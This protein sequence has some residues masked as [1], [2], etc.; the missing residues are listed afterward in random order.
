MSLAMLKQVGVDI[1]AWETKDKKRTAL[2]Q[3]AARS[4][5]DCAQRLTV[6]IGKCAEI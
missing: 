3:V 2:M 1:N 5:P 4:G 6:L